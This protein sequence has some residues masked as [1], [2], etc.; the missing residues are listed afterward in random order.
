VGGTL[1]DTDFG[2]HTPQAR[3]HQ[4]GRAQERDLASQDHATTPQNTTPDQR[5]RTM[6]DKAT[7][8]RLKAHPA[9][10]TLPPPEIEWVVAHGRLIQFAV[11]ELLAERGSIIED[12]YIFL[13]GHV[14]MSI[15][16]GGGPRKVVEW[17]GGEISGLLPFSRMTSSLGEARTEEQLDAVA[18][19]RSHFPEL[20]RECPALSAKLVQLMLDRARY[21][22]YSDLH[23]EKMASLG[24]LA[25]GLAHEL[26]NPASAV[27]RDAKR[28]TPLVREVESTARELGLQALPAD[29]FARLQSLRDSAMQTSL[30]QI[31]SPLEQARH[32]ETIAN[33]LEDRGLDLNSV[34]PLADSPISI[35][36]LDR[37]ADT[38]EGP[39]LNA[40]IQ[41]LAAG[42]AL[43]NIEAGVSAAA[44]RISELVRAV[45]GFTQVDRGV[46]PQPVDIREGLTQTVAILKS[47]ARNKS[48]RIDITVGVE[49]PRALAVSGDLNQIW[50][51]LLDNALDAIPDGGSVEISAACEG[52][53]VVVRFIDDGPGVPA[54]IRDRIF[55]PFFTTK[56]VGAGTGLG[57]DIVRRL[58]ELQNGFVELSTQAGRT[59]FRVSLPLAKAPSGNAAERAASPLPR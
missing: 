30:T 55:D 2:N 22:A 8:E 10:R 52:G 34:E 46:G 53:Y 50:H 32:E 47:K 43:W 7:I 23:D 41:W 16:R 19:H 17:H 24:R 26:D 28:L 44:S 27:L 38:I 4:G 1:L 35:E 59:E 18:V 39:A 6:L 15:D 45:K 11:N 56:P 57:L 31:R 40:A 14:V 13:S 58:V 49:L 36:M 9:I 25:A 20:V 33:W 3:T 48:A 54:A 51:N 5:K 42:S 29:Q 37:I 12:L 21:F